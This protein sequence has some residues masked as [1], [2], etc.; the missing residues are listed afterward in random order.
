MVASSLPFYRSEPSVLPALL[1]QG[2]PLH[3]RR[4]Q[5]ALAPPTAHAT[6]G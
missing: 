4:T 3:R 6:M 2:M 5:P 1:R